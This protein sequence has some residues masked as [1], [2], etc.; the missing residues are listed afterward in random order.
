MDHHNLADTDT[1][2]RFWC[3]LTLLPLVWGQTLFRSQKTIANPPAPHRCEDDYAICPEIAANNWCDQEGYKGKCCLSCQV[4]EDTKD[5]LCHDVAQGCLYYKEDMCKPDYY[6]QECK[7]TCGL[8]K[9][10]PK[11]SRPFGK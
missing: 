4:A 11:A 10:T 9:V 8:C 5:P 7:K 1:A 6:P 2:M 3:V